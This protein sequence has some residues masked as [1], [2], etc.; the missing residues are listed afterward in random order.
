MG[1]KRRMAG[2]VRID[3]GLLALKS[4]NGKK[5]VLKYAFVIPHEQEAAQGFFIQ[6]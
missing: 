4:Q 1:Y 5:R 2:V 3:V 6:G